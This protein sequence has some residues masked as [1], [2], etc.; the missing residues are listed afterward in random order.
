MSATLDRNLRTMTE[1]CTCVCHILKADPRT[2][3]VVCEDGCAD[4][5]DLLSRAE[6]DFDAWTCLGGTRYRLYDE[7]ED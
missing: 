1:P 5:D 4:V 7:R 3:A 2:A 6:I